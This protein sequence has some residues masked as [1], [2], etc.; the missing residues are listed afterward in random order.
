MERKLSSTSQETGPT[1]TAYDHM[2]CV[3]HSCPQVEVLTGVRNRQREEHWLRLG[4]ALPPSFLVASSSRS[5][6]PSCKPRLPGPH[7]EVWPP[8]L[9][10]PFQI[11]L[12]GFPGPCCACSPAPKCSPVSSTPHPKCLQPMRFLVSLPLGAI[13]ATGAGF[14]E[15]QSQSDPLH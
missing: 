1:P 12:S 14:L 15:L 11:P 4:G 10:G 3:L 9:R 2:G 6:T 8:P 5:S 13:W 7:Q